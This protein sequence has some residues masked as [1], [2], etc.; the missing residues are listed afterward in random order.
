MS[1]RRLVVAT[2]AGL[3]ALVGMLPASVL[4]LDGPDVRGTVTLNEAPVEGASV[5][6][7]VAGS[8]MVF[9]ATTDALG[10]W[11]VQTGIAAGSVLTITAQGPM[12]STTPD[13]KGCVT[14][15]TPTGRVELTVEALPLAPVAV[16]LGDT[17]SNT[18]CSATATPRLVPTPPATDTPAGTTPGGGV[19]PLLA[20]LGLGAISWLAVGAAA[21][22]RGRQG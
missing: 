9:T 17:V 20:I 16:P 1:S 12:V 18:V 8:D 21:R 14:Q 2:V 11:G 10:V 6:V 3:L 4:A 19:G 15:T 7:A 5:Q 13:A 22:R